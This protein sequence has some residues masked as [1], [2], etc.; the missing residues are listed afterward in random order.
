[1]NVEIYAWLKIFHLFSMV[2]WMV[3]LFYLPR[4]F[5]YHAENRYSAD[6]NAVFKT[7]EYK[8]LHYIMIPAMISTWLFGISLYFITG[9]YEVNEVWFLL[10]ILAVVLLTIFTFWCRRITK[11]FKNDIELRSSKFFRYV[12]ELP[13]LIFLVIL[14]LVILRPF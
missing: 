12:N 14:V 9:F 11:K 6:N 13:T 5:V 8:L 1:M 7:M 4:I 3:G 10:K 2:A